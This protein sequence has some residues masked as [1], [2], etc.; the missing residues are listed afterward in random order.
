[1][2]SRVQ[3]YMYARLSKDRRTSIKPFKFLFHHYLP[4]L[5]TFHLRLLNSFHLVALHLA[6]STTFPSLSSI[7]SLEFIKTSFSLP[8]LILVGASAQSLLSLLPVSRLLTLLPS[9]LLLSA[10]ST[11][12]I[13]ITLGWLQNPFMSR[14]KQ[15]K[16]SVPLRREGEERESVTV[17]LLGASSNQ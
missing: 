6:S 4:L 16:W 1:M 8:T 14:V 12:N 3:V 17:F 11:K 15:G 13:F 2:G 7:M 9:I 10:L 5:L